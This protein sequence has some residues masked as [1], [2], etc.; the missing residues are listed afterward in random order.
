M[1]KYSTTI[2]IAS[3]GYSNVSEEGDV[4]TKEAAEQIALQSNGKIID[5]PMGVFG[6]AKKFRVV[7]TRLEGTD[8][9]GRVLAEC[10]S[11]TD[12]EEH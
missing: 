4:L 7:S 2:G 10:E 9:Q 8:E 1:E 5:N 3:Y 6:P 11:V 12:E